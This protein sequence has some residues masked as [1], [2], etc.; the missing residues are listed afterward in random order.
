MNV[1]TETP[2]TLPPPNQSFSQ[3]YQTDMDGGDS[4]DDNHRILDVSGYTKSK[5]VLPY[6]L[7]LPSSLF[8][9]SANHP[10]SKICPFRQCIQLS[11]PSKYTVRATAQVDNGALW[12]CIGLHVWESYGHCLGPLSPSNTYISVA[13]NQQ[14][15]CIGMWSGN[16][17]LGGLTFYTYFLIF[18]CQGAFDVILGKP[19]L[20]EA[21]AIHH[22][23]TDTIIISTDTETAVIGNVEDTNELPNTPTPEPA[24][25][26]TPTQTSLDDLILT[27]VH[28]I[29]ALHRTDGPFAE[30][31]WAQYLDIEPVNEDDDDTSQKSPETG[32]K[33]FTTRA[34]QKAIERAK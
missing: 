19:W 10:H 13:N 30:S 3:Y 15:P 6:N 31:R 28:H 14:I 17:S 7:P 8:M 20:H 26:T 1:G 16:I 32:V 11:G 4:E 21:C 29:E 24:I 34:E 12:N 33:W 9:M 2:T 23:A 5:H 25:A 22:Y 18:D 27:E